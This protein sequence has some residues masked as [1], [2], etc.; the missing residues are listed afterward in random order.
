[1]IIAVGSP[2]LLSL[3]L[4]NNAIDK[5]VRAFLKNPDGSPY[6]TPQIDLT[7][8]GNGL[9]INNSLIMPNIQAIFA[10]FIVYE[11]SGFTTPDSG[12]TSVEGV[13]QQGVTG[14]GGTSIAQSNLALKAYVMSKPILLTALHTMNL[15]SNITQQDMTLGTV[16]MPILRSKVGT[17][18]LQTEVSDD[19]N[20]QG[21]VSC[22]TM[23]E[24]V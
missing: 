4:W 14:G 15:K 10:T 18:Q 23:P 3:Q 11:D 12:F 13:Y 6:S 17:D 5:F 19:N 7:H 9:Y 8:V 2:I 20:L 21:N 1:M 24:G 16:Q 22:G